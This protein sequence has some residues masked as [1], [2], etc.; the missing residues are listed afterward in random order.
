M[1]NTEV[2]ANYS[3]LLLEYEKKEIMNYPIVY[4]LN[5]V[6]RKKEDGMPKQNGKSN[7]GWSKE[8][9]YAEVILFI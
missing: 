5:T 1:K 6:E 4:Y 8:N 7:E 2:L 3:D 9:G